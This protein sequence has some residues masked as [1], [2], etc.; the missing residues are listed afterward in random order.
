MNNNNNN[1]RIP[2]AAGL[3]RNETIHSVGH[4][5][6]YPRPP[7]IHD[8]WLPTCRPSAVF[9]PPYSSENMVDQGE[10]AAT[11]PIPD[12]WNSI[13]I[14]RIDFRYS[15]QDLVKLVET[16]LKMGNVS[17][18]DF[19]PAKE[20]SGRMAFI[21]MAVF[22]DNKD[23]RDIRTEME[24]AGYWDLPSAYNIYPIIRIRFVINRRPV[25]AT[26]FTMETLAD[27][28]NRL[29]YAQE[30][31][32]IGS[33]KQE[34]EMEHVY[35]RIEHFDQWHSNAYL[36]MAEL[37]DIGIHAHESCKGLYEQLENEKRNSA[38]QNIKIDRLEKMV[39]SQ[40]NELRDARTSIREMEIDL[41]T[42]MDR[43]RDLESGIHFIETR[44]D[45]YCMN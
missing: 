11:I 6:Q 45:R 5:T 8:G 32:E 42:M 28:V 18:I 12:N 3:S 14:P 27:A 34:K 22:N 33:Q 39:C 24:K 41:Q 4:H 44:V 13:F 37:R 9:P 31:Q 29:T 2:M 10:S 35:S 23:T 43:V 16:E 19:A 17:R 38:E 40:I 7:T 1:K 20:G 36:Q 21:H 25:P 30:H 15:R 26:M